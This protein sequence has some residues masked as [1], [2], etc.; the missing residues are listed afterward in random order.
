MAQDAR[1]PHD[2]LDGIRTEPALSEVP[3]R[4]C[5]AGTGLQVFSNAIAR[6]ALAN[7]I[8]TITSHGTAS[9][10]CGDRPPL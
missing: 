7:T 10:V 8:D 3:P 5:T 6:S 1:I 4:K 9:E 2:Q